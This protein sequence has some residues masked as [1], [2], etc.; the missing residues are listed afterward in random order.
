[1]NANPKSLLT[2]PVVGEF[3]GWVSSLFSWK[4]HTHGQGGVLYSSDDVSKTR[5]D[6]GRLL[7]RLGISVEGG[8]FN[9]GMGLSDCAGPLKCRM[10]ETT[11]DS[12]TIPNLKPVRF[13]VEF[14]FTSPSCNQP[15]T[16]PKQDSYFLAAPSEN[17]YFYTAAA[18]GGPRPRTSVLINKP[19]Q[20][21]PVSSPNLGIEFPPGCA[22]AVVFIHEKGSASSFR[23][24]WRRLKEIYADGSTTF[25]ICSPAITNTPLTEYP[26][27]IV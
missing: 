24:V 21:T 9:R 22:T 27:R 16:S 13:R 14:S 26:Q 23:V 4:N 17:P 7:E 5:A 12:G 1:V 3:K 15:L 10:E 18:K 25:S 8:G 11:G 2:S 19:G 20:I 6:I